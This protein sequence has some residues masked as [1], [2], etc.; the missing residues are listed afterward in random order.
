MVGTLNHEMQT[1]FY[2][3]CSYG[4]VEVVT[5]MADQPGVL[6]SEEQEALSPLHVSIAEGYFGKL[7]GS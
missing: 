7:R 6:D 1:A 4:H 2:V 5:Y 3:A